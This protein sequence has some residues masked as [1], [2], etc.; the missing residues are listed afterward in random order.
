[1]HVMSW[2]TFFSSSIAAHFMNTQK[3]E[4]KNHISADFGQ[5]LESD[6]GLTGHRSQTLRMI[7][8][9]GI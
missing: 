7:H 6:G 5:S 2:I 3:K 1:M 4:K 8:T 9:G